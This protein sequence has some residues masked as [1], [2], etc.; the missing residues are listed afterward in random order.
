[1]MKLTFALCLLLALIGCS[2]HSPAPTEIRVDFHRKPEPSPD[3]QVV[4]RKD[5]DELIKREFGARA[6]LVMAGD[7]ADK[8]L[9]LGR[10]DI[11]CAMAVERMS[12][13]SAAIEV[14]LFSDEGGAV[15]SYTLIRTAGHWKITSR[16]MVMM[17]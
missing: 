6:R 15:Y 12:A 7:L 13:N 4:V 3:L 17:S 1:M 8:K 11:S 10:R 5:L 9:R 16:V 2:T 14:S